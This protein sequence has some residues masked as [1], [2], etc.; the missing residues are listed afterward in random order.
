MRIILLA[1]IWVPISF[2]HAVTLTTTNVDGYLFGETV[3]SCEYK[4]GTKL[5][6][7]F[8]NEHGE[9]INGIRHSYAPNE[10]KVGF[11][12]E[13]TKYDLWIYFDE[14]ELVGYYYDARDG[15]FISRPDYVW[16]MFSDDKTK[17]RAFRRFIEENH[18]E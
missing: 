10:L 15:I 12:R 16:C 18:G 8:Y 5:E 6:F 1:I 14:G 11:Y 17:E 4:Y 9:H 3:G 13:T 7:N 2:L